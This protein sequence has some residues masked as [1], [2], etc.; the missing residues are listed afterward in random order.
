MSSLVIPQ[1]WRRVATLSVLFK[2]FCNSIPE[3]LK[4]FE[5]LAQPILSIIRP[6]LWTRMVAILTRL[7]CKFIS[8]IQPFCMEMILMH[9][10]NANKILSLSQPCM[11]RN[12]IV[13]LSLSGHQCTSFITSS[14]CMQNFDNKTYTLLQQIFHLDLNYPNFDCSN[15]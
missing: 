2:Y 6:L 9:A 4:V 10:Q 1:V 15:P 7:H 11:H 13:G 3:L 5:D 12:H 8:I 14:T